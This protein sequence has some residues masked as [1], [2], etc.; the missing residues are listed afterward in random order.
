LPVVLFTL[1]GLVGSG[2]ESFMAS[3]GEDSLDLPG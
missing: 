3:V 1:G 2:P